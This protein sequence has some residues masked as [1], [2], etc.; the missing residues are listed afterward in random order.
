MRRRNPVPP[1]IVLVVNVV[2]D[3]VVGI[4]HARWPTP[5]APPGGLCTAIGGV[6]NRLR[7]QRWWRG[8]RDPISGGGWWIVVPLWF[9]PWWR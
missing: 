8:R 5:V 7:R 9:V 4:S 1:N 6:Q 3:Q 2:V